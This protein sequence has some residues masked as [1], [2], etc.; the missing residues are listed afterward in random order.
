MDEMAFMQY[1]KEIDNAAGSNSP[2]IIYNSTP[3]GMGNQFYRKRM[4]TVPQKQRD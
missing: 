1:A 3:N 4:M 2:C